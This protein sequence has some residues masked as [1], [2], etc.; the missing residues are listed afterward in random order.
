MNRNNGRARRRP[1]H[2]KSGGRRCGGGVETCGGGSPCRVVQV[3]RN[4]PAWG[5]S[6][7]SRAFGLEH[8]LE[9]TSQAPANLRIGCHE[10]T[11]WLLS[12]LLLSVVTTMFLWSCFTVAVQ[13][14]LRCSCHSTSISMANMSYS[15]HARWYLHT[16]VQICDQVL[17]TNIA[18]LAFLRGILNQGSRFGSNTL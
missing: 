13:L 7:R 16:D 12:Y 3:L 2:G 15:T 14:L 4:I 5:W 6:A 18:R 11:H 9:S 1:L 10:S 8:C 17:S